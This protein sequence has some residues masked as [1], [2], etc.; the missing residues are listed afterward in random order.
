VTTAVDGLDGTTVPLAEAFDVALLD[1]D[2]VVYRGGSV[3]PHA[4]DALKAAGQAGMR[5]AYVTNNALRPPESVAERLTGFGVPATADDVVTSAQ[6]AARLLSERLDP[7]SRVLVTGGIGLRQAVEQRGLVVVETL[8]DDPAAVVQGYDPELTYDR[9]SEA[10]LAIRRGCLW[11]A[12]NLDSTVPAERGLL[13][14]AGSFVALLRTATDREPVVA[15]KP[16]RALHEESVR[17]TGAKQ[18]LVVGDRLDTDIEGAVRAGTP[19]ML[20]FTGVATPRDALFARAEQRPTF[21]GEDLRALLEPA[22]EVSVEGTGAALR[23]TV[24]RWCCEV[25]DGRLAWRELGGPEEA[26]GGGPRDELDALRAACAVGWAA[27]DAGTSLTGVD[28][29]VPGSCEGLF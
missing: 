24:G 27:Q 25:R 20:V 16:E 7:G 8:E 4:A 23:V 14:G 26:A 1:L 3:I 28:G 12:S 18:P 29:E 10:A 22:P 15:G 2:G 11:V 9:L 5:L 21:L 19:S 13:P 17:R 6:A